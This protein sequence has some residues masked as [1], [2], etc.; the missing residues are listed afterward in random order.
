MFVFASV[1]KKLK[2]PKIFR[3]GGAK[4]IFIFADLPRRPHSETRSQSAENSAAYFSFA[5]SK[6][7][8]PLNIN[9]DFEARVCRRSASGERDFGLNGIS[10]RRF[11]SPSE[12]SVD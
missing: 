11:E 4:H 7:A 12:R 3:T 5:F 6:A 10:T 9:T 2:L 8:L 1:L